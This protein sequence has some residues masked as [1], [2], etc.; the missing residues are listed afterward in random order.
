[1]AFE[2]ITD[3]ILV[4]FVP[5]GNDGYCLIRGRCAYRLYLNYRDYIGTPGNGYWDYKNNDDIK[6]RI[7]I[8][9]IHLRGEAGTNDTGGG[10]W[11]AAALSW[12]NGKPGVSGTIQGNHWE[13][14]T[15]YC[16]YAFE[17]IAKVM[18]DSNPIIAVAFPDDIK[19]QFGWANITKSRTGTST[20]SPGIAIWGDILGNMSFNG[21][22]SNGSAQTVQG[23]YGFDIASSALQVK[24][25]GR[26]LPYGDDLSWGLWDL[27]VPSGWAYTGSS[28]LAAKEMTLKQLQDYGL[29]TISSSNDAYQSTLF[30]GSLPISSWWSRWLA[31][32]GGYSYVSMY[33]GSETNITIKMPETEPLPTPKPAKPVA[34]F[35]DNMVYR[36]QKKYDSNGKPELDLNGNP[37][38]HWY[39]CEKIGIGA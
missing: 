10:Y 26:L 7:E 36:L 18:W 38:L 32:E 19:G 27:R 37:V 14:Y 39:K 4:D 12:F 22:T 20:D 1:M 35:D 31:Q 16:S 21:Y 28:A 3:D 25:T 30:D 8:T 13:N 15:F 11:N 6:V 2:Q 23:S 9:Y 34:P 33:N 5:V 29:V 24:S 17:D